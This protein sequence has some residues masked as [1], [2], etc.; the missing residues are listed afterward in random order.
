MGVSVTELLKTTWAEFGRDNVAR[1]GAAFAY[2]TFTSFFPLVLVL[3]SLIGLAL[4][5]GLDSAEN[6]RD[7]VISYISE[8]LPAARELLTQAF[9]DTENNSGTLGLAG[10]LTGLWAASNIFAQLEEAF[11]VIFDVSPRDRGLIEKL[12][13]RLRAGGIVVIL[14]GVMV[15]SLA[16]GTVLAT[17]ESLTRSLPYGGATW[18]VINVLISITL[19]AATFAL[20]FKTIPDK[21]VT[22]KGALLGALFSAVTWQIGREILTAYLGRTAAGPTAGTVVGS[23]LA[24]LIL[25]YYASQILMVGAQMTATY[26][27]L[28]HP[29]KVAHKT[30][31]SAPGGTRAEPAG[32]PEADRPAGGSRQSAAREIIVAQTPTEVGRASAVSFGAGVLATLLGL[33]FGI[34]ALVRR[35][36]GRATG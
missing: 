22:W 27:E 17:A 2:Y 23:V 34:Q 10:L 19:T 24:F 13:A 18:W 9:Q 12:M 35:V 3:I 7:L 11:N 33:L 4:S 6:A 16:A 28:A 21:P 25:V 36:A 32:E 14:A 31:A 1:L 20:L 8:P 30:A 29:E 5:F 15:A 26:D